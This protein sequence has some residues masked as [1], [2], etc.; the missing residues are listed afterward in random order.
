MLKSTVPYHMYVNDYGEAFALFNFVP[1][2]HNSGKIS[3][4]SLKLQQKSF[5]P[6]ETWLL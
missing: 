5:I 2:I 1:N 3:F 4:L 6:R